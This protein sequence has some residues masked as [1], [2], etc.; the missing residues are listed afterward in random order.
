V[1]NRLQN[2]NIP[3]VRGKINVFAFDKDTLE[4]AGMGEAAGTQAPPFL[5]GCTRGRG[6]AGG[7]GPAPSRPPRTAVRPPA[8]PARAP[9]SNSESTKQPTNRTNERANKQTNEQ[10][11]KHPARKVIASNDVN[12]DLN[13]GEVPVYW[14]ERRYPWGT[15]E[16]FNPDHSDLLFLRWG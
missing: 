15:A 5:V 2:P 4:R 11:N 1:F 13:G 6:L 9:P 7:D 12:E 3:G 16:A 14:P 10:A 8:T